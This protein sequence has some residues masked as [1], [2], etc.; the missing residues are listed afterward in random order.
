MVVFSEAVGKTTDCKAALVGESLSRK[1]SLML[2]LKRKRW[3]RTKLPFCLALVMLV[4]PCLEAVI[5]AWMQP[6]R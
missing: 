6:M 5:P 2:Y 4:M 3:N 1:G